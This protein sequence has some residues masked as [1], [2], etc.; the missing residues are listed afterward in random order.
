MQCDSCQH[1]NRP[2]ARFCS[3]C[4]QRLLIKC[5]QC[6]SG[7]TPNSK[8]CDACGAPLKSGGQSYTPRHLAEKALTSRFAL[9]GEVK[10]VTVLF[11][12][13]ANSTE[14]AHRLG[15]EAMHDLL[16]EFFELA[17]DSRAMPL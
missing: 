6:G 9:E 5:P 14:L 16:N 2:D 15:P 11:C 4:G 3:E 1:Q 8:F 13:I 7:N 10:Q 12:D 17:A